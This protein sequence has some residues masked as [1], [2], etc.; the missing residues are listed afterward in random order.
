MLLCCLPWRCFWRALP[1]API[2][3]SLPLTVRGRSI[4]WRARRWPCP[5]GTHAC[6]MHGKQ[7]S[8]IAASDS[9][10]S[11]ERAELSAQGTIS[12]RLEKPPPALNARSIHICTCNQFS[13]IY[14]IR[15]VSRSFAMQYLQFEVVA[16][17]DMVAVKELHK[18]RRLRCPHPRHPP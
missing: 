8:F 9:N 1:H 13:G 16:G 11:G 5:S 12:T 4:L 14:L 3:S 10:S 7:S 2:A 15:F 18:D 17:L 6:G